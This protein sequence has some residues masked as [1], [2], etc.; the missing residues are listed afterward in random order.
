[1]KLEIEDVEL[2]KKYFDIFKYMIS[3]LNDRD[4]VFIWILIFFIKFLCFDRFVD[5][6][7]NMSSIFILISVL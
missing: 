3:N 1:M 7:D 4:I 2:I 6:F 5:R